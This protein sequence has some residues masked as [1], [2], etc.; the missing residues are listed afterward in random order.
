MLVLV[1]VCQDMSFKYEQHPN[2]DWQKCHEL[3]FC[4]SVPGESEELLETICP[5]GGRLDRAIGC[6]KFEDDNASSR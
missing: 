5:A 2:K 6:K 3:L 4:A 1:L